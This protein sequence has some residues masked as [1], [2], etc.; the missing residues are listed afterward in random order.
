MNKQNRTRL[1]DTENRM[2]VA[3]GEEHLG[4][5]VKKMEGFKTNNWWLQNSLR[6]V[7]YITGN[8]VNSIAVTTCGAR[9]VR[10]PSGERLLKSVTV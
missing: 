1:L 7:K 8:T 10:E 5:W 2:M 4:G 6:A 3:R 9:W